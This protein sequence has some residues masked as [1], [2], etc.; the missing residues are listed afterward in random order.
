M[1]TYSNGSAV[2]T[3]CLPGT[4]RKM[5]R[6]RSAK[7]AN[8]LANLHDMKMVCVPSGQ[9]VQIQWHRGA[10]GEGSLPD[11][12]RRQEAP[13]EAGVAAWSPAMAWKR[14]RVQLLHSPRLA[15]VVAALA[16]QPESRCLQPDLICNKGTVSAVAARQHP[17]SEAAQAPPP[18]I[19]SGYA[20]SPLHA[21]CA[22]LLPSA[23]EAAMSSL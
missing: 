10:T 13:R 12:C 2:P 5:H 8:C 9:P 23:P 21:G 3:W 11:T 22:G 4:V 20:G 16:M 14:Q 17:I 15:S 19:A 7:K 18:S 1:G 6:L